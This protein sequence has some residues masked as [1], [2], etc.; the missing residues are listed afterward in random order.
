MIFIQFGVQTQNSVD[1]MLKEKYTELRLT[2]KMK[3]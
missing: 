1:L 2:V 3:D